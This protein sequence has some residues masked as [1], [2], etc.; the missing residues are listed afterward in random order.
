MKKQFS[1]RFY[2]VIS[3]L[4]VIIST[5]FLVGYI[6]YANHAPFSEKSMLE[7]ENERLKNQLEELASIEDTKKVA[8]ELAEH[9]FVAMA[10]DD[11]DLLASLIVPEAS[12]LENL[13]IEFK[14][15]SFEKINTDYIAFMTLQ[16]YGYIQE[17]ASEPTKQ[18]RPLGT[19]YLVNSNIFNK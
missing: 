1:K 19:K 4:A 17:K 16:D 2:Q 7:H 11:R 12:V 6:V 18:G 9:F 10:S 15:H 14:N 13:T 3:S 8:E 5:F